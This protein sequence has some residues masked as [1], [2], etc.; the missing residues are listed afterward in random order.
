MPRVASSPLIVINVLIIK[1]RGNNS[2]WSVRVIN[3]CRPIHKSTLNTNLETVNTSTF[4]M[5][6]VIPLQYL[7]KCDINQSILDLLRLSGKN[8]ST[9]SVSCLES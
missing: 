2:F 7:R 6:V 4:N 3:I 5:D 8:K 1:G 9:Y